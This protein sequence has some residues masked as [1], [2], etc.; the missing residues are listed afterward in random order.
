MGI[1]VNGEEISLSSN[2]AII[3]NPILDNISS[4]TIAC[5]VPPP[6]NNFF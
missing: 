6:Q 2:N 1:F 4:K 5:P 3:L